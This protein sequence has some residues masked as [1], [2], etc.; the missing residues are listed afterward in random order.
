MGRG[1]GSC[2]RRSE[3][4]VEGNAEA[5]MAG[6]LLVGRGGGRWRSSCVEAAVA[7]A[8]RNGFAAIV[9]CRRR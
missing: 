2:G 1:D 5:M 6:R 9:V 8:A 7:T 3:G 4:R